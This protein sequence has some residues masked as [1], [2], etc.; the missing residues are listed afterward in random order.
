MGIDP[1]TFEWMEAPDRDALEKA[2]PMPTE[3]EISRRFEAF[4]RNRA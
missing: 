4:L 3:A 1:L 2:I